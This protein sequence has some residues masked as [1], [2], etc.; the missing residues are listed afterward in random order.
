MAGINNFQGRV[1]KDGSIVYSEKLQNGL[2]FI[3]VLTYEPYYDGVNI[4]NFQSSSQLHCVALI[5][6]CSKHHWSNGVISVDD[7]I[8]IEK[9]YGDD[10][11]GIIAS[12]F[13]TKDG[14]NVSQSDFCYQDYFE[15]KKGVRVRVR[16]RKL[17]W[18]VEVPKLQ[19]IELIFKNVNK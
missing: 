9:V 16:T 6:D 2:Y 19:M 14:F 7:Y 5:S 15:E 12:D 10:S 3:L 1:I 8:I 13:K 18:I 17:I 4:L 11:F